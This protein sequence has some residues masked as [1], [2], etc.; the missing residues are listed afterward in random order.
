MSKIDFENH[1]L[2]QHSLE[3]FN[4]QKYHLAESKMMKIFENGTANIEHYKLMA[5]I[6]GYRGL[7]FEQIN[8]LEQAINVEPNS[9]ELLIMMSFAKLN[10]NDTNN[11]K[12]FSVQAVDFKPNTTSM[13]VALGKIYHTLGLFSQSANCYHHA[14]MLEPANHELHYLF[15]VALTLNGKIQ[16]AHHHLNESIS[17]NQ[18]YSPAFAALSKVRKATSNK[19]AIESLKHFLSQERNPYLA[20][21]L[22][23]ALAKELDDLGQYNDAFDVLTK[24]KEKLR[25]ACPHSPQA[26]SE[27]VAKLNTLYAK[28][29][30][31]IK[32]QTNPPPRVQP[33]FVVGMPRTGTTIVERV[34]SNAPDVSTVGESE[35]FSI[36]LK[37][38]Y[39]HSHSGL[40]DAEH[41]EKNW[42]HVDF[43][44]LGEDYINNLKSFF[45][46]KHYFVDKLP[47]NVLLSGA[48][49]RALPNA[50][51]ICLLRNPLDTVI[52]NYRQNFEQTS[53]TYA[54]SLNLE[55]LAN[56]V[57]EFRHLVSNLQQAFPDQFKVIHYEELVSDPIKCS[58]DMFS[59]CGLSWQDEYVNIHKNTSPI[60]TAS[61]AQVKEPIHKNSLGN[62]E[63]YMSFLFPLQKKFLQT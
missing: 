54:Y 3:L 39:K 25:I 41:L 9:I 12:A 23:H 19:N 56:F 27:N 53:G 18:N 22:S 50:R 17:L 20:I 31:D 28:K 36:L 21:N 48:I 46:N 15:G 5:H 13:W 60:G 51:I 35:Q 45:G 55:S 49:L 29:L 34:L 62:S 2:F 59:F 7:I 63:K 4:S 33:I 26:A 6:K 37:K 40:V 8:V 10:I 52:G 16:K 57:R 47:L 32:Q 43:K 14:V 24:G 30:H 42:Q 58:K 1:L 44:K 11:A 38:N 61:A